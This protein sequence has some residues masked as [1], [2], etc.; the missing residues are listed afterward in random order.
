MSSIEDE[1][2]IDWQLLSQQG[3]KN[4]CLFSF[5]SQICQCFECDM[6][7]LMPYKVSSVAFLMN[8]LQP[9]Q[10]EYSPGPWYIKL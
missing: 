7:G 1:R 3:G 2:T 5:K 9:I 10:V 4:V 8:I 6:L